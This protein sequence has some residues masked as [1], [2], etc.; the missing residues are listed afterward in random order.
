MNVT[1]KN[2]FDA[3]L[4]PK[5]KIRFKDKN[6]NP[7]DPTLTKTYS[8]GPGK[9]EKFTLEYYGGSS[10]E[11]DYSEI[12]VFIDIL[13]Y[14][15]LIAYAYN[16]GKKNK[17]DLYISVKKGKGGGGV[18]FD[19]KGKKLEVILLEDGESKAGNVE[20]GDDRQNKFKKSKDKGSKKS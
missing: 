16:K 1:L 17:W 2:I 5:R 15:F 3:N 7:I 12:F 6:G 19:E 10:I 14:N 11:P 8:I 13:Y 9:S 4:K 18:K 20:V